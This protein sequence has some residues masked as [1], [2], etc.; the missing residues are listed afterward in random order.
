MTYEENFNNIVKIRTYI[1]QCEIINSCIEF[2][3]NIVIYKYEV[4]SKC[5]K[6]YV[7]ENISLIIPFIPIIVIALIN[8]NHYEFLLPDNL[9]NDGMP[10]KY[11]ILNNIAKSL[12]NEI[13]YE[14]K[15][16]NNTTTNS[17]NKIK[18]QIKKSI[19]TNQKIEKINFHDKNNLDKSSEN[20]N[21]I[22]K[23]IKNDK[24][25]YI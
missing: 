15:L 25:I 18:N 19:G 22:E 8:N 3:C 11:N 17:N 16:N 5:K 6:I 24:K 14:K 21:F 4:V 9:L 12:N 7:F 2:K 20:D 1:G 23:N 10:I 13:E